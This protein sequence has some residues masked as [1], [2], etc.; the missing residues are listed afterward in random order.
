MENKELESIVDLALQRFEERQAE[1]A[2]KAAEMEELREKIRKEEREK[3]EAEMKAFKG[4]P[5]V[6][7]KAKPGSGG[8]PEEGDMDTFMYWLRTGDDVAA[9][10]S[11]TQVHDEDAGN[12][13]DEE[14]R[15]ALS[16]ASG[17]AGEYL[18][19]DGF[20][21]KIIEKRDPVSFPRK[22]GVQVLRTDRKVLDIPAEATSLTKF[23]R[24]AELGSYSTNDPTFAQNQVTLHK[25]TK[26]TRFSEELLEDHET[27]LDEW[28]ARALARAWAATEAY[29]VAVGTGT[30]QHEGIFTGGDTDA[31]TLDTDHGA[32]SDGNITGECLWR[33]YY[34]LG[35][36][37][38]AEAAWLMDPQTLAGIVSLMSNSEFTFRGA[39]MLRMREDG[40]WLL[41][42]KPVYTQDDIPVQASGTCFIMFG[43]PY[44]YALVESRGLTI[45]RNPYLYQ[46][47]GEVGVFSSF[48]Q[49]G[50]VVVE[51][52]WVGAVGA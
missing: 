30:N 20:V 14:T 21:T 44:Y 34:T 37:Y 8:K 49:G 51:E 11:L 10:K 22:M 1:K 46:A 3:L 45:K 6:M 17:A 40:T 15:K 4:A 38:Q 31:I 43:D 25:W 50:K 19:P 16:G 7:Q 29:Y 35:E 42:G 13:V 48:R 39:D 24:T 36:G 26:V 33:I 2:R 12:P 23:V 52:A 5:A 47:T 9:R 32:D 27:D 41:L 18:M 28:Y